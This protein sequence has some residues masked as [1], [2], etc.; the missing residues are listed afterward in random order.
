M[1]PAAAGPTRGRAVFIGV[2]H[3]SPACARLV[4]DEIRRVRPA[5]V[6]IEGPADFTER[7]G[8]L[9]LGHTLPVAVFSHLRTAERSATSW[10]PLCD[11]SP[12]WVAL[13]EGRAIGAEVRFIDLPA[14]HP[15]FEQYENRYAD[16][17]SRYEQATDR[18][19]REFGEQNPDAL[20][21][22]LI[23][24]GPPDAVA[25]RLTAYFDLVRGEVEADRGD[26]EREQYMAAWIRAAL[27]D[28]GDRPVL[29]V[30]GGFHTP[31][32]RRLAADAAV[33]AAPAWPAVPEPPPD[34]LA[35]SFLVPYTFTRLDA[36]TGYQSG[37][38]S[39]AFYQRVW[40]H[41]GR[42]AAD[43][44]LRE[45]A[46]RLRGRAQPVSTA[47]LIAAR[48]MSEG[49][50]ALRGHAYPTRTD[51]FDALAAAL[52]GEALDQ[53]LPWVR[54][55][56]LRSGAHPV[57]V[58][59]L[60]ASSGARAGTLDPRTPAPPLVHEVAAL[61]ARL[62]LELGGSIRLDLAKSPRRAD[63]RAL[64]RLRVLGVP[65]TVRTE[66]PGH[67]ADPV[68]VERWER[69]AA[70]GRESALIE[71]GAYGAT[72]QDAAAA[73]LEER[74]ARTGRS[75]GP[76][77]AVPSESGAM[78]EI[79]FD[80]VLCGAGDL[81]ARIISALSTL[82]RSAAEPGEPG[83][84]LTVALGLWRHDRVYDVAHSPLLAAVIDG[85][86]SRILWLIEGAH[87][88]QPGNRSRLEAVAAV[89]DAALYAQPI[90]T[91]SPAA[92]AGVARRVAADR[93]APVDVRGAAFGLARA[94]DG[95][96]REPDADS[97]AHAD[98]PVAAVRDVQAPGLIGDWLCGQFAVARDE[99]T[100]TRSI[101]AADRSPDGAPETLL[102]V[103][104]G[105]VLAMDPRDFLIALPALRQAFTSFPPRERESIADR[106]LEL[107]GL[108]G[109]ARG[110]LSTAADPVVI[111]RAA[112][113]EDDVLRT[114]ERYG[115]VTERVTL[116]APIPASALAPEPTQG[117]ELGAQPQPQPVPAPATPTGA[118]LERWRLILGAAARSRTGP[119]GVADAARDAALDWLYGRDEEE[120]RRGVRR[121]APRD[122]GSARSGGREDSVLSP[123]QWLDSVH[124]LFPRETIERLERDAV[125]RYEI[126]EIVTDPAVLE[127][128]EPDPALLRAVLRTKHLMNPRVL[129]L[130]RRIVD[131][132]VRDLMDRLKPE[133]RRA[134]H[135][136]RSRRPSR[137][138]LARDFD[139]RG[140]VRANLA[141]YQPAE[142][143]LLIEQP[144]FHSRTRRHLERW[145][146]ILIVDQSGSMVGSVIHSAVTAAC[147]W[148]LPG[149]GTHLIA[150]DTNVVDLTSE[151]TDPVELLMRVQLGGGTDI[152]RAVSY[153]ASLVG[154]PRRCIMALI[155]DFFE[156]GDPFQLVRTV[157]SLAG[158]GVTVL[159]LAALDEE[160]AP[161]YD[162]DLAQRLADAGAHVGAMTP[163]ALAEFVAERIGR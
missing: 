147:L 58:E 152:A 59:I 145:Q 61:H 154:N 87:D 70:A 50:A 155:T 133:V 101:P 103:L 84:V 68:I 36:F 86:V 158:Q 46:T 112:V 20:W 10:T 79:L 28:A 160:A 110:L 30:T 106:L 149:L 146:L 14:W 45:V 102:A 142:R 144:R 2:R 97:E 7:I 41:G 56:P 40:E 85:A 134:F 62:G 27:A 26:R 150:F 129:T 37:M 105:I 42:R 24:I 108:R 65:G 19:C 119:L 131:Q 99:I 3:H 93:M 69:H 89:R 18:L 139:F 96:T 57:A 52:I 5:H 95:R 114:L 72:L 6:L 9:L 91:L 151:V 51:T 64:H 141:H 128:I 80:A 122:P 33:D 77:A 67:S 17:E 38:P 148:G 8:E 163:G 75:P 100:A 21:D 76:A 4:R 153:G 111:A 118:G 107:R 124:R 55:T 127:R 43:D 74:L 130:A 78:A 83:G 82:V 49:L 123:V 12:E 23:E 136:S 32:L 60:A 161:A 54:R 15:A 73:M 115:L 117:P 63:S 162:R 66:G 156:G 31:A 138:P 25:E 125:E 29:V 104:D 90:L 13:T 120:A 98:D 113:L 88:T 71:A 1:V 47:D 121:G 94:L 53:P 132:V 109:F 135:G 157:R 92:T 35:G 137:L 143:R 126:H 159:G 34:S 116:S 48:A 11:Y 81:S 22:A 44:L 140:T 39:P 16:P